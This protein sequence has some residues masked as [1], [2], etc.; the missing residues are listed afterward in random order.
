MTILFIFIIISIC[1]KLCL[2]C[3]YYFTLYSAAIW[4]HTS[5]YALYYLFSIIHCIFP[6]MQCLLFFAHAITNLHCQLHTKRYNQQRLKR[7]HSR[8]SSRQFQS[9]AGKV[10]G[11]SLWFLWGW[12]LTC[13][14]W[15]FGSGGLKNESGSFLIL[16]GTEGGMMVFFG[17]ITALKRAS[18]SVSESPRTWMIW[19]PTGVLC[20][21]GSMTPDKT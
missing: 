21:L 17:F 5:A 10:C 13:L 6:L 20:W 8:G 7:L 12:S 11:N 18:R 3:H 19:W 16:I 1:Y 14:E 15:D 4:G 2:T 9:G